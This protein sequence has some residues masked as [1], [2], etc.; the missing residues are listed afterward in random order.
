[1]G[2]DARMQ[3]HQVERRS[4][5]RPLIVGLAVLLGLS[6]VVAVG[7]QIM[8]DA[9]KVPGG[10]MMSTLEP[11]DRVLAWSV[12][13]RDP[14]RG[15]IVIFEPPASVGAEGFSS[16]VGRVVGVGGDRIAGADGGLTLNGQVVDE[17]YLSVGTRTDG[18]EPILV[19]PDSIYVLGDNRANARDSRSYGPVPDQNVQARVTFTN[20]PLDWITL[21]AVVVVG[22]ALGLVAVW[23]R[24]RR[25]PQRAASIAPPIAGPGGDQPCRERPRPFDDAGEAH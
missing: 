8:F 16:V 3:R 5:G 1:L 17:S 13:G 11:G 12:G 23:P 21:A 10:S 9:Y 20:F 7:V 2:Q 22:L 15:D 6:G 4:Y 25:R 14:Q 19:P 18:L 24:S